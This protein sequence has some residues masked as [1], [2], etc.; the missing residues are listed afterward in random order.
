M[1]KP[2]TKFSYKLRNA[3]EI[4]YI[5]EKSY[6]LATSGRPGPVLID[7][8]M[9]LQKKELNLKKL[10]NFKLNLKKNRNIKRKIKLILSEIEKSKKPV[11]ILGGELKI[12]IKQFSK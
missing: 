3:N 8:P 1:S 12:L 10:K 6:Y 4:K 11:I 5:L 2:I 7:I 9:D